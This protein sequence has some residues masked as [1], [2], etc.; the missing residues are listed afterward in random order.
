MVQQTLAAVAEA[1]AA[2][3]TQAVLVVQ[4]LSKLDIKY[5]VD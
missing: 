3:T 1:L 4:A 5:E 2:V